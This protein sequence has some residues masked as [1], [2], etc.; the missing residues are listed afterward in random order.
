[1]RK[2]FFGK[3][4]MKLGHIDWGSAP[5]VGLNWPNAYPANRYAL[6]LHRRLPFFVATACRAEVC[7]GLIS[8]DFDGWKRPEVVD[9]LE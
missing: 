7:H 2:S 3:R 4:H 5:G 6:L 9:S 1:M 8:V